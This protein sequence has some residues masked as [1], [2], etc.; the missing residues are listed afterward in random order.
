MM[1]YL[2]REEFEEGSYLLRQG[3]PPVG[4]Y[5][6]ESGQVTAQL[7]ET[8]GQIVRLRKMGA[9]TVVGEMGVYLGIPATASVVTNQKCVVLF[10][11]LENLRRMEEMDPAIAAIFHKFIARVLGDR[12][13]HTNRT[14][15]ALMD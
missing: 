12:L 5:F 1:K 9:G 7:E 10:L 6:I 3:N 13:A 15:R 8:D 4:L 2:K 11:S 14:V